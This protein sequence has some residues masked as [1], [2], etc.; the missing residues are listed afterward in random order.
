MCIIYRRTFP[1]M[2]IPAPKDSQEVRHILIFFWLCK[3]FF[4]QPPWN[5]L[6]KI[7]GLCLNP[8]E[9]GNYFPLCIA[10]EVVGIIRRTSDGQLRILSHH[11]LHFFIKNFTVYWMWEALKWCCLRY[12]NCL[13]QRRELLWGHTNIF[14]VWR[15]LIILFMLFSFC[16]I[17]STSSFLSSHAQSWEGHLP[18]RQRTRGNPEAMATNLWAIQILI[19]AGGFVT[20]HIECLKW[21]YISKTVVL[22]S[23]TSVSNGLSLMK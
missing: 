12:R 21:V 15:L 18:F 23:T 11:H 6:H 3:Y 19:N 20:S 4:N 13:T 14:H 8:P 17:S 2:I 5:Q 9:S 7:P 16:Y 1:K 22:I 10:W